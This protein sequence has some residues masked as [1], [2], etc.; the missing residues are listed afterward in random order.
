MSHQ[1]I[2]TRS[3]TAHKL[4]INVRYLNMNISYQIRST[5]R[6]GCVSLYLKLSQHVQGHQKYTYYLL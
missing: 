5:L 3:Q 1:K 6:Q 4:E 2:S